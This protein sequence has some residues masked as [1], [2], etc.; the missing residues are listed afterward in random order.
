[1]KYLAWDDD[2]DYFPCRIHQRKTDATKMLNFFVPKEFVVRIWKNV[3]GHLRQW[4][5]E[6]LVSLLRKSSIGAS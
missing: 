3:F 2:D 6:R 4:I 1:M 5:H